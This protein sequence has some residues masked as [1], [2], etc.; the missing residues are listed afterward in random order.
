[1]GCP[2]KDS[3][4]INIY[5]KARWMEMSEE[6]IVRSYRQAANPKKQIGVLAELNLTNTSEIRKILERNGAMARKTEKKGLISKGDLDQIVKE[7]EKPKRK[8]TRKNTETVKENCRSAK[9]VTEMLNKIGEETQEE[10]VLEDEKIMPE[11]GSS[12]SEVIRE[13]LEHEISALSAHIAD[14]M[15]EVER[16]K[17]KREEIE[18]F[19]KKY[20]VGNNG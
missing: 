4:C 7:A 11:H 14:I 2:V 3:P 12:L 16:L 9:K 5:R 10:K 6:E 19:L 13:S 8:Y 17:A 20:E 18:A 15:V 1:M